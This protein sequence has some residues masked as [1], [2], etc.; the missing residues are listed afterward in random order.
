M[1]QQ[2]NQWRRQNPVKFSNHFVERQQKNQSDLETSQVKKDSEL[3]LSQDLSGRSLTGDDA[4]P[5]VCNKIF[6]VN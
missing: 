1:S 4:L 5:L 6:A 3:N 2:I